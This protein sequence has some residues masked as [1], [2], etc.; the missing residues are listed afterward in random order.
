PGK[1]ALIVQQLSTWV[2]LINLF[3]KLINQVYSFLDSPPDDVRTSSFDSILFGL[4]L[5][6]HPIRLD[7]DTHR[8]SKI[9]FAE[10]ARL[11]NGTLFIHREELLNLLRS[12]PAIGNVEVNI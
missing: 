12:D 11:A 2:N 3:D 4:N 7:L 6:N 1:D 9:E 5:M 10:K 8:I